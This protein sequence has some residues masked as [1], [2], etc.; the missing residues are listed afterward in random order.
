MAFGFAAGLSAISFSAALQ[1]DVAAIPNALEAPS[2]EQAT[3]AVEVPNLCLR[4]ALAPY[5]KSLFIAHCSQQKKDAINHVPIIL[6]A[7]S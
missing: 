2:I 7:D 6:I 1:K 5:T 4:Q 3:E